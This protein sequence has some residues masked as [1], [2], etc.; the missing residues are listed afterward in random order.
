MKE[1]CNLYGQSYL[2]LLEKNMS[3]A[4]R[5]SH[6]SDGTLRFLLLESI[7][8]NP[9]RGLFVAIDDPERGLHPD[10]IR[11]VAEMIK[12]STRQTQVII[13]TH[14]PHLLNL[15]ELEDFLYLRKTRKI[16]QLSVLYQKM[17]FQIGKV[18][19]YRDKC[20]YWFK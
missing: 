17:I 2:S 19:I 8:Y 15:F 1:P 12:Y 5:A 4:I 3:R 9:L 20:G 14:S 11:S 6:I 13:A 18:N 10:M 16:L 7:F